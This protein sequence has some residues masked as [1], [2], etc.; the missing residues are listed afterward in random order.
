LLIFTF[1]TKGFVTTFATIKYKEG[2]S[3]NYTLLE[4]QNFKWEFNGIK[5]YA[6][7]IEDNSEYE[8]IDTKTELIIYNYKESGLSKHSSTLKKQ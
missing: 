3:E 5:T 7:R 8:V 1:Y 4:T 2:L 6:I